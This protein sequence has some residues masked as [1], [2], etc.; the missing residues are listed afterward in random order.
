MTAQTATDLRAIREHLVTH[1]WTQ[2]EM[3]SPD[4]RCC[5][6]GAFDAL[7]PFV[8][9][10]DGLVQRRQAVRRA[11]WRVIPPAMEIS[12]W[13]DAPGRTFADV[14]AL[15]DQAIAAEEARP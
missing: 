10:A 14:L 4:G 13:N 15:L 5:V 12:D 2:G 1:G 11:L 3:R 6:L 9:R 8:A 7:L